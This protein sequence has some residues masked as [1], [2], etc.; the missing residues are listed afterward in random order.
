[1]TFWQSL[2]ATYGGSIAFLVAC[3]LLAL[4]PVVFELVQHGIEVHIG[5]YDSIAAAK[6]VE[7]DPLRMGFGLL[8]VAAL[9]V[10]GYWIARFLAWRDPERAV[11]VEPVA[12]RLFAGF[13][14]FQLAMAVV[15]LFGLPQTVP[16][17]LIGFVGGMVIGILLSAWGIAAALGNAAIGPRAS[18]AMMARQIPW[19]F[20]FSLAAM[21]PLMVP[22]YVFGALAI[23]GPKAALWPVLIVDSLLVGWLTAVL[24]A[25]SYYIALRGAEK[26]GVSLIPQS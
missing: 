14:V 19:A 9:I 13:V 11:R 17:L 3:P 4:F 20:A 15:Q 8:K 1:M 12:L 25:A 26:A 21:L 18:A 24:I 23:L 16:A 6:A 22:H 10:P 5:M 7:H 2:K